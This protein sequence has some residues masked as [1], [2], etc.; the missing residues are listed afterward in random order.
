MTTTE[1]TEPKVFI[2]ESLTFENE[3]MNLFEGHI[4]SN[5]LQLS[6][7]ESKYFYIRTKKEF[8]KV[9]ELF[10]KSNYRYLHVSC[11][12]GDN[13]IWTTLDKISF[14]QLGVLTST[15]LYHKRLFLSACSV[16]NLDLAKQIIPK[17]G[18]YSIIGPQKNIE[19]RDAAIM[20][21]S[22]YH[23]MFKE[24]STMM[25]RKDIINC[26]QKVVNTFQQPFCYYSSSKSLGIKSRIINAKSQEL[27]TI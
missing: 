4:I 18:C 20:W 22:F 12:G 23:L 14:E 17:T 5:I 19:F 13:S 10:E 24:E 15:C 16:V 6:N 1:K 8:E 27:E 21:A 25:S 11:H 9:L 26:L 7:I 2:I 3:D